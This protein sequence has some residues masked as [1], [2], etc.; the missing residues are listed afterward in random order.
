[1]NLFDLMDVSGSALLAERARAEVV[2]SNLAN[3][4]TTRTPEGG[5]YRRQEVVFRSTPAHHANFAETLSSLADMHVHGVEVDQVVA[6][7]S[8]PIRR[9]DPTHPDADKQGYVSY[10]NIN[11]I[12]EMVDLMGAAR[13][14]QLNIAAVQATKGMIK[15]ALTI[16]A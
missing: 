15:T 12:T 11:P 7:K 9:F 3:S 10:P 13:G 1:M 14:Y 8:D 5:P 6:D 4:E 16:L 2:T